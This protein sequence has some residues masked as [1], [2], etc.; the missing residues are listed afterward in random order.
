MKTKAIYIKEWFKLK[1][2]IAVL[3]GSRM[4]NTYAVS[5][6]KDYIFYSPVI[7]DFVY[8]RNDP[9]HK[10]VYGTEKETLN[11]IQFEHAL[12]F[13]FWK[14]LKLNSIHFLTLFATKVRSLFL[15]R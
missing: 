4:Y 10:F 5:H 11:K 15:K 3:A 2:A 9:G 6:V 13:I 14:N 1:L 8:Q 12:P 7:N